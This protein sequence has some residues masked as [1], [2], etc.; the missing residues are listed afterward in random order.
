MMEPAVNYI[1]NINFSATFEKIGQKFNQIILFCKI[2]KNNNKYTSLKECYENFNN[3]DY[4]KFWY[5]FSNKL[6]FTS[7]TR[8]T[9]YRKHKS[10]Y[11]KIKK[12]K[13][14]LGEANKAKLTASKAHDLFNGIINQ[15][16][17]KSQLIRNKMD[18]L[19]T[20]YLLNNQENIKKYE[21]QFRAI[22]D[23]DSDKNFSELLERYSV[24]DLVKFYNLKKIVSNQDDNLKE[25]VYADFKKYIFCANLGN[26]AVTKYMEE[27]YGGLVINILEKALLGDIKSSQHVSKHLLECSYDLLKPCNDKQF[28]FSDILNSVNVQD[29]ITIMTNYYQNVI[30]TTA[31]PINQDNDGEKISN[32][33]S[34]IENRIGN[35]LTIIFTNISNRINKY[36]SKK[37]NNHNTGKGVNNQSIDRQNYIELVQIVNKPINSLT[38]EFLHHYKFNKPTIQPITGNEDY[39]NLTKKINMLEATLQNRQLEIEQY[40]KNNNID[41]SAELIVNLAKYNGSNLNDQDMQ[42]NI[43]KNISQELITQIQKLENE[44]IKNKM[45]NPQTTKDKILEDLTKNETQKQLIQQQLIYISNQ[46]QH[47]L[48]NHLT[49][50]LNFIDICLL[51][52]QKASIE[53]LREKI[54]LI[55]TETEYEA[56]LEVFIAIINNGYYPNIQLSVELFETLKSSV[57]TFFDALAQK[58]QSLETMPVIYSY[59]VTNS[60]DRKNFKEKVKKF[61]LHALVGKE[62]SLEDKNIGLTNNML[63]QGL[64]KILS[65]KLSK[66]SGL[67]NQFKDIIKSAISK[68]DRFN[69]QI[70]IFY[71]KQQINRR[72]ITELNYEINNLWFNCD[73]DLTE[74]KK[75]DKLL[76]YFK[77][78]DII[79][80]G[81]RTYKLESNI[82]IDLMNIYNYVFSHKKDPQ[83]NQLFEEYSKIVQSLHNILPTISFFDINQ[84]QQLDDDNCNIIEEHKE[85]IR[86]KLNSGDSIV[87]I[88]SDIMTKNPQI[89]ENVVKQTINN[90][91][92]QKLYFEFGKF[93]LYNKS[94]LQQIYAKFDSLISQIIKLESNEQKVDCKTTNFQKLEDLFSKSNQIPSIDVCQISQSEINNTSNLSTA[95]KP[96]SKMIEC[97]D[98]YNAKM[99]DY[100]L[101]IEL[102]LQIK[103]QLYK[104]NSLQQFKS[105]LNI[106]LIFDYIKHNKFNMDEESLR[107]MDIKICLCKEQIRSIIVSGEFSK[108][109]NEKIFIKDLLSLYS[110]GHNIDN[111]IL[112]F[113]CTSMVEYI[114]LLRNG[115]DTAYKHLNNF[116][117]KIYENIIKNLNSNN[118]KMRSNPENDKLSEVEKILENI[119]TEYDATNKSMNMYEYILDNLSLKDD[120][121]NKVLEYINNTKQLPDYLIPLKEMLSPN[122]GWNSLRNSVRHNIHNINKDSNSVNIRDSLYKKDTE[123][124]FN[125]IIE[126]YFL[127][128]SPNKKESNKKESNKKESNKKVSKFEIQI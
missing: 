91:Q 94:N 114:Q 83:S 43:L 27:R 4:K 62:I 88:L 90:M 31:E 58:T 10:I 127:F 29:L 71:N 47:I 64:N 102:H 8:R 33:V 50:L 36:S 81:I 123:E 54:D 56:L 108:N 22:F 106:E 61:F 32:K 6:A 30:S 110:L 116:T 103:S 16:D 25:I 2:F 66:I 37:I 69:T 118:M 86:S 121:S 20:L 3:N 120:S 99:S 85:L 13:D 65:D 113:I 55:T 15:T 49:Q 95:T 72:F 51:D 46:R 34:K 100:F 126:N 77:S 115:Q 75:I 119:L 68:V 109:F 14:I 39:R 76:K 80:D 7:E 21:D 11:G 48:K 26:L 67:D 82:A 28:I 40:K 84:N 96:R 101:K 125:Q 60:Q 38:T 122:N 107:A 79:E 45:S 42:Q 87:N 24:Y 128:N 12:R 17:V 112:D 117:D 41:Q 63:S 57:A 19:M 70:D 52:D 18:H 5:W 23:Q 35:N 59:L 104:D 93:Y 89:D 1:K 111:S 97:Y 105:L 44:F 98:S 9:V 78:S 124:D 53:G 92:Y 74:K 73:L